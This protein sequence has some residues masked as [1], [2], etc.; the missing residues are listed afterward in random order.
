VQVSARKV[1]FTVSVDKTSPFLF[2]ELSDKQVEQDLLSNVFG[3]NA[4]WFSDN[5]FVAQA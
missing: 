4:G 3:S 5:N 2:F 1:S